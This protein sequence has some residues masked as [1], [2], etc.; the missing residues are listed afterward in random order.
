MH[1]TRA[2]FTRMRKN[3]KHILL[4]AAVCTAGLG[5]LFLINGESLTVANAAENE[6]NIYSAL[7]WE[8]AVPDKKLASA[9]EVFAYSYS[10]GNSRGLTYYSAT[11]MQTP[12]NG[13][14]SDWEFLPMQSGMFYNSVFY[15]FAEADDQNYGIALQESELF[16]KEYTPS[17]VASATDEGSYK[18]SVTLTAKGD[19]R[20]VYGNSSQANAFAQNGMRITFFSDNAVTVEKTWYVVSYANELVMAPNE[21]SG[22][23]MKYLPYRVNSWQFGDKENV[24]VYPWLQHGDEAYLSDQVNDFYELKCENELVVSWLVGSKPQISS[25]WDMENG[26]TSDIVT[27]SIYRNGESS[28]PDDKD[29]GSVIVCSD[30]PRSQWNYYVNEYMPVGQYEI[31]FRVKEISLNKHFGYWDGVSYG[32]TNPYRYKGFSVSYAFEVTPAVFRIS[33]GGFKG[34]TKEVDVAE[35]TSGED[36]FGAIGE[37]GFTGYLPEFSNDAA[38]YWALADQSEYFD[39]AP[40]LKFNL[41]KNYDDVYYAANDNFWDNEFKTPARYRVF[42]Q[43]EAKNYAPLHD[44]AQKYEYYFDIVLYRTLSVPA[45]AQT[46]FVYTGTQIT[47]FLTHAPEFEREFYTVTG[48]TELEANGTGEQ[49]TVTISLNDQSGIYRW[50]DSEGQAAVREIL[51]NWHVSPARENWAE[52]VGVIPWSYKGYIPEANRFTGVSES[53]LPVTFTV[54]QEIDG[55]MRPL[56]YLSPIITENGVV[57]N[58]AQIA[59]LRDLDAGTYYIKAAVPASKNYTGATSDWVSFTVSPAENAWAETPRFFAWNYGGYD[60]GA[61]GRFGEAAHGATSFLF[62]RLNAGNRVGAGY[63]DI[64]GFSPDQSYA[65]VPAGSYEMFVTADGGNNYTNLE[66]SVFFT[67]GRGKNGWLTAPNITSWLRGDAAGTLVGT[68]KFGTPVFT[69]EGLDGNTVYDN[70]KDDLSV[71]QNLNAG[72]YKL[73]AFVVGTD[74]YDAIP[75]SEVKFNVMAQRSNGWRVAPNIQG[76]TE[77]ETPNQPVGAASFGDVTFRYETNGGVSVGTEPP[78]E[79]GEYR[80]IAFVPVYT[81][82][83]SGE[84]YDE[85]YAEVYFTIAKKPVLV[86]SWKVVPSIQNWREG[87]TPSEPAGEANA[88]GA[89]IFTYMTESGESLSARPS[90][91]GN[92]YLVATVNAN[93]YETLTARVPFTVLPAPAK[94]S[95]RVQDMNGNVLDF[96]A[97]GVPQGSAL[98]VRVLTDGDL[99]EDFWK[100][101]TQAIARVGCAVGA[102]YDLSLL[103]GSGAAV[104]PVGRVTVTFTVPNELRSKAGLQIA[105]VGELG[106]VELLGG[107]V[108]GDK[109]T[110]TTDHFST[111]CLVWAEG[112][113]KTGN[114]GGTIFLIVLVEFLVLAAL[115]TAIYVWYLI[116]KRTKGKRIVAEIAV[117]VPEG[118]KRS[119]YN[120]MLKGQTVVPIQPNDPFEDSDHKE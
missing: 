57:T 10:Y 64:T 41:A 96:V 1:E 110:F 76:W 16:S 3:G 94:A 120:E 91:A 60:P 111:F 71:L 83:A 26:G 106:E 72:S 54:A 34:Q 50:A 2:R 17:S 20:F 23:E 53:G 107:I 70:R 69:V 101:N 67:I 58:L 44:D 78:T 73:I 104:Q 112:Q 105:Y 117:T 32:E 65:D 33:D 12:P 68:P 7:T 100:Y 25:G 62:Y 14:W 98:G 43:A 22:A 87:E 119:E 74:D 38:G 6:I 35:V 30:A 46:K 9:Q 37:V 115:V 82:S 81:D 116:W 49:Y 114:S 21:E 102:M 88:G 103:D 109:I 29:G 99:T 56:D 19:N 108:Q 61:N 11:E 63:G 113:S 36:F 118:Q 42:Y 95:N 79:A 40:V 47:A 75:A 52:E 90:Q 39:V 92:Y 66:K 18:A 80:L 86:N 5:C 97:E 51:L 31:T 55:Q 48:N 15:H 27:F 77:G 59:V 84:Q 13:Y 89:T 24:A 28:D 45:L 93:G 8:S 85:L 4:A